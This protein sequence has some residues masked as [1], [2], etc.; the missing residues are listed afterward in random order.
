MCANGAWFVSQCKLLEE[1]VNVY[2][3][4]NAAS[5]GHK[6]FPPAELFRSGDDRYVFGGSSFLVGCGRAWL[7]ARAR[8]WSID[9]MVFVRCCLSAFVSYSVPGAWLW[10]TNQ[11]FE[12]CVHGA[13]FLQS[14]RDTGSHLHDYRVYQADQSAVRTIA[15]LLRLT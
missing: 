13:D 3:F 10:S 12:L 4:G 1:K 15:S 7:C 8:L 9:Q 2:F 14:L 5:P 11:R 6:H